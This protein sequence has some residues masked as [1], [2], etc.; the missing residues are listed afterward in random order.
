MRRTRRSRP[1]FFEQLEPRRV[2]SGL[3]LIGTDADDVFV[4]RPGLAIL[5]GVEYLGDQITFDG[6]GG[7]D[8]VSLYGSSGNDAFTARPMGAEMIG[9]GFSIT[10]INAEIIHGYAVAGGLD[11]ARLYDS[12]GH[13]LLSGG[14]GW[15][16]LTGDGYFLR[17]KFFAEFEAFA[18]AGTDTA[19]LQDSAGDD[20]FNAWAEE[21]T[22][23]TLRRCE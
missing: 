22:L 20:V 3:T 12:S 16:K 9:D 8:D 11:T 17:A 2:L 21:A 5:N 23:V 6:R 19:N 1:A 18:S 10:V 15:V 13:D 14:E 4:A 7:R